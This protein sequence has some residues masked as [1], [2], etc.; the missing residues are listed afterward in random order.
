M[1]EYLPCVVKHEC[2]GK[3]TAIFNQTGSIFDKS[4]YFN[5]VTILL[6]LLSLTLML[7]RNWCSF[8]YLANKEEQ[9]NCSDI[10]Y[11]LTFI[12]AGS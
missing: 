2:L 1:N 10:F 6:L 9:M 4:I 11:S 3:N 5:Q 7:Q 8:L 12:Q